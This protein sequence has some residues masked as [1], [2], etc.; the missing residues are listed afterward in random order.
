MPL[1]ILSITAISKFKNILQYYI[2]LFTFCLIKM[3]LKNFL[4]ESRD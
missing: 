1:K 4:N 2:I 3:E